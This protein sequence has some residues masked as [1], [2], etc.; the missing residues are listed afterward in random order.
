MHEIKLKDVEI[1]E[2]IETEYKQLKS[3]HDLPEY[4]FLED[5]FEI[6]SIDNGPFL[7]R[8]IR[9]KISE[10]IEFMILQIGTEFSL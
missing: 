3:K 4:N 6:S 9:R 2:E 5:K 7:L 1:M 10:K 8:N